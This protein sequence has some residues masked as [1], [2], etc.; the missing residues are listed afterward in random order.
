MELTESKAD[1]VAA[2][3]YRID[4]VSLDHPG[5][6][7]ELSD[8]VAARKINIAELHTET[9]A[10]PHTG[11]TMFKCHMTVN[12]PANTKIAEFRESILNFC[13]EKNLDLQIEPYTG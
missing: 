3:P 7:N 2:T 9:Y 8:F 5:I 10:A 11:S 13:D 12:I 1:S 4:V 6:V